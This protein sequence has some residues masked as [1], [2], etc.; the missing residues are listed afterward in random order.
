MIKLHKWQRILALIVVFAIALTSSPIL[1]PRLLA[2]TRL[3]TPTTELRGVWLTNIDSEVMFL[4]QQ[5]H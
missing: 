2:Q 4:P 1:S 5:H 3:Q